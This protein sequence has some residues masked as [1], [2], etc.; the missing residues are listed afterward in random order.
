MFPNVSMQTKILGLVTGLIL[1]V[2]LLLTIFY[3]VME[4]QRIEQEMGER[5]LQMAQV[6]AKMP[7]VRN[8]FNEAHPE[9]ILQPIATEV[10]I[11]SGAEYVVIG[12]TDSIR[13]AHPDPDKIG[14]KMVGGDN[15]RA[16]RGGESY[17]SEAVGSLG[18]SVRGKAPI[19]DYEDNIVGVVSVG[20]MVEDIRSVIY[21]RLGKIIALALLIIVVGVIGGIRLA[22]SI[23]KDTMGLEPAEIASLYT[24]R[25]AILSSVHEGIIAVNKAGEITMLNDSARRLLG[26]SEKQDITRL[27]E[28][29]PDLEAQRFLRPDARLSNEEA[30]INDRHVIVNAVPVER[31]GRPAGAVFS[32]R[33]KTELKELVDTLSEVREYSEYL[34]AQTHEYTNKLYVISGLMQ[35]GNYTEAIELISDELDSARSQNRILFTQIQDPTVQAIL[36]GKLGKASEIKVQLNIDDNSGLGPL[37]GHIGIAQ[38][39]T[40]LGNL[41]DNAMEE[42]RSAERREVTFFATDIGQE[43]IFEVADSGGGLPEEELDRLY[44]RGYSTKASAGRGYG[45]PLVREVVDELGG[46]IEAHNSPGSGAVFTVFIPKQEGGV[47]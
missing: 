4:Y 29:Q 31:E 47:G 26:L 10:R 42:V 41:L 23:R 44:E 5:G 2:S 40:V 22:D 16:L 15:D 36:M 17:I 39:V 28:V 45:L 3:S 7:S 43:I 46:Y 19:L 11:L 32:F 35:L 18:P 6:V 27:D 25:T 20:F 24:E 34:R 1:F 38:I 13:Y 37:P 8:A 9:V 14:K 30:L 21:E 12:N 33:D